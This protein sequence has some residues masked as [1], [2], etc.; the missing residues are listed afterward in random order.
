MGSLLP[1]INQVSHDKIH[2]NFLVRS[3]HR[4]DFHRLPHLKYLFLGNNYNLECD[5]ETI[6]WP[7]LVWIFIVK[8]VWI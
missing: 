4:S 3:I 5:L 6:D 7:A 2:Y 8:N 1:K